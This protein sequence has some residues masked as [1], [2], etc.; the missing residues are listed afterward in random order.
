MAYVQPN[1]RIEFFDDLGISQDYNDTLYF[2]S[3]AAKDTYFDNIQRLAHVDK[4]YYTRDNRG[5]VR[6]ELPMTTLIHAQYMRFKNTS[7]EN[8]WWYAFVDDVIYINDNTTEVKF[9]FDP[10]LSWMG[11]FSVARCYI[12][13]QHSTTDNV[14]DNIIDEPINIG[15]Y[16]ANSMGRT[17]HFTNW[18]YIVFFS[19]NVL[20]QFTESDINDELGIYSGLS[21]IIFPDDGTAALDLNVYRFVEAIFG[22][23]Q[24]VAYVPDDF[25]PLLTNVSGYDDPNTRQTAPVIFSHSIAR[26]TLLS[27]IDGYTPK[28]NKL[29]TA[30]YNTLTVINTEGA[31][32]DYRI[33]FFEDN[34]T[35]T[36][37][38]QIAASINEKSQIRLAPYSYKGQAV[39][40]EEILT[41]HDFPYAAWGSD[42]FMAYM[43]QSL[44]DSPVRLLASGSNKRNTSD[45][46]F[47]NSSDIT[48][49]II[50][51]ETI[52]KNVVQSTVGDASSFATGNSAGLM[53]SQSIQVGANI[54]KA[55]LTPNSVSGGYAPDVTTLMKR[56]D[57]WFIRKSINAQAARVIDDYFTMFG[58]AQKIVDVPNMN[59][60][61]YW[62]YVKTI[63]CKIN[64]RCPA[65]DADFIEKCF[66]RGI[67]FW[68][69]HTK[70]GHYELTN[71]PIVTP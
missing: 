25:I 51:D 68:K 59:A 65:S 11:E 37:D 54:G 20:G 66:N 16:V 7:Y 6:V 9:T 22:A 69:D 46:S 10:M 52:E 67:R 14:G 19:P 33:E 28:N 55:I 23:V 30:P 31:E 56:K 41:M 26:S 53:V 49:T 12:E 5:F 71:A 45:S 17:G 63:Q 32:N 1:S 50:G 42:A 38:F 39:N 44:S 40:E 58:Y 70:I 60:R 8:K 43:A 21:A 48:R 36:I 13:R 61:Q 2:V 27:N 57:F 29:Y 62:T 34:L 64:C 35:H 47:A 18:S 3:T 15:T 24:M 4:C